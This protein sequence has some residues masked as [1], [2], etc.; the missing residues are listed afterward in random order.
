MRRR[1][2][3]RSVCRGAELRNRGAKSFVASLLELSVAE[4]WKPFLKQQRSRSLE[5]RMKLLQ[6]KDHRVVVAPPRNDRSFFLCRS[7]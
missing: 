1:C 3:Q 6:Q 2:G 4:G 7:K 5:L